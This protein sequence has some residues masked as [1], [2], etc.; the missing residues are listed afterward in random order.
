MAL[1]VVRKFAQ[2]LHH[3]AESAGFLCWCPLEDREPCPC[4]LVP[5]HCWT[6]CP[7]AC[8]S[9]T[10]HWCHLVNL[11]PR[12]IIVCAVL[13]ERYTLQWCLNVGHH[14]ALVLTPSPARWCPNVGHHG[15]D[16]QLW[17][18]RSAFRPCPTCRGRSAGRHE[19]GQAAA[20]A[21]AGSGVPL[22]PPPPL[23]SRGGSGRAHTGTPPVKV[24][25]RA[26]ACAPGLFSLQSNSR[27]ACCVVAA[28]LRE[29]L[30]KLQ[31]TR[32]GLADG[33]ALRLT[34]L[35]L[36]TASRVCDHR[37]SNERSC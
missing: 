26:C 33:L 37:I 12:R 36:T 17:A 11:F 13:P 28:A 35:W 25:V 14:G 23:L 29:L 27:H 20:G 10:T 24:C 34:G 4:L 32:S 6:P 2:G 18:M 31:L 22:P 8:L 3:L 19:R 16:A 15:A 9:T 21:P 5:A 30:C 7:W 1:E